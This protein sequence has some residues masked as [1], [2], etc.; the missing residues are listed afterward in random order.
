MSYDATLAIAAGLKQS[1]TR[2]GLRDILKS[3]GFLVQGASGPIQFSPSV[4][5]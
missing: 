1:P 4:H 2:Q 3:P 5:N